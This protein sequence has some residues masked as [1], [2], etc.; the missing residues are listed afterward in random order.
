[1]QS[2]KVERVSQL[3]R[4][5]F[6]PGKREDKEVCV[7]AVVTTSLVIPVLALQCV[8]VWET[9]GDDGGLIASWA[10]SGTKFSLE[11]VGG[12][13]ALLRA[14]RWLIYHTQR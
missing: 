2:R 11:R 6:D 3:G 14:E 8:P 4:E 10:G 9:D 5:G 13:E 1:M 12:E 7:K